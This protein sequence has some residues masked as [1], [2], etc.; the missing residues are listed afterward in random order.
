MR[1]FCELFNLKAQSK[2]SCKKH[3]RTLLQ[4]ID[5]LKNSHFQPMLTLANTLERWAEPIA[6]F[7]K[8][9]GQPENLL[10]LSPDV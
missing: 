3:I 4:Y 6:F 7:I 10:K 8:D 9:W 5:E 1:K 2:R